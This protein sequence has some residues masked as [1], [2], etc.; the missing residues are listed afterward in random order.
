MRVR[1]LM[2]T[3]KGLKVSGCQVSINPHTSSPNGY[4]GRV[5]V[6]ADDPSQDKIVHWLQCGSAAGHDFGDLRHRPQR[7]HQ[8][9]N[10]FNLFRDLII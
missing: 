9:P 10:G 7:Q 4:S 6:V 5:R 8:E 1:P 2:E 3:T